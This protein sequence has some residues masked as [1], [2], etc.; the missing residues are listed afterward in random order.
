MHSALCPS[1]YLSWA[2]SC[3]VP[4]ARSSGTDWSS[5]RAWFKTRQ[6]G[7]EQHSS[8]IATSCTEYLQ[9]A[10]CFKVQ[11]RRCKGHYSVADVY[12][13]EQVA[14]S[15]PKH[16]NSFGVA[17]NGH[18]RTFSGFHLC[19]CLQATSRECALQAHFD[20]RLQKYVNRLINEWLQPNA[21]KTTM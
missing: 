1:L 21:N 2:S 6:T 4:T 17:G 3:N 8:Q 9:S 20:R 13:V 7:V 16:K 15:W 12:M 11:T 19:F 5:D 14:G 10:W 18:G